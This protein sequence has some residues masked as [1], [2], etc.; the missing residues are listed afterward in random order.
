[1]KLKTEVHVNLD[2]HFD[3]DDLANATELARLASVVNGLRML[4]DA[5]PQAQSVSQETPL[6]QL[7][8]QTQQIEAEPTA[9]PATEPEQPPAPAPHRERNQQ[10]DFVEFDRRIRTEMQRLATDGHMPSGPRW[11]AE[12]APGLP[13]MSGV[14]GRYKRQC[15]IDSARDLAK[16]FGLK[17]AP[18]GGAAHAAPNG[19]HEPRRRL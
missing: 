18:V 7:A 15:A 17:P 5:Q 2:L 8:A 9:P 1:M 10:R 12:K 3:S 11:N 13:T 16:H 14:I 4:L 6:P 19:H